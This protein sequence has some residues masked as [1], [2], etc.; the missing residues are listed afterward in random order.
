MK[1]CRFHAWW[2][3]SA[4]GVL[5]I[6]TTAAGLPMSGRKG[7]LISRPACCTPWGSIGWL[8]HKCVIGDVIELTPIYTYI[9][10][11]II[12][13]YTPCLCAA[14]ICLR[15]CVGLSAWWGLRFGGLLKRIATAL[16]TFGNIL[17]HDRIRQHKKICHDFE[18]STLPK[19]I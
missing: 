6:W 13:I 3:L 7:E 18:R 1:I 8:D 14:Q 10:I 4:L 19:S 12:Y 16:E 17:T 9:C 2:F 11:Y 15:T 5:L